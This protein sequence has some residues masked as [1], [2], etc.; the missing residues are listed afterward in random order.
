[1]RRL[2]LL[3]LLASAPLARAHPV[4]KDTHDRTLVVR[5]T[6]TGVVVDYRL[7]ADAAR[8][9]EDL[10]KEQAAEAGGDRRRLLEVYLRWVAEH[11]AANLDARLDGKELEFAVAAKS[12]RETDSIACDVRLEAGWELGEGKRHRFAF[13]EACLHN[14]RKG[15]LH[16]SL[17]AS[18]SLQAADIVAPDDADLRRTGDRDDK[19]D[20]R[21][22]T[23]S[24][25]ILATPEWLPARVRPALPP[26][27]GFR[28]ASTFPQAKAKPLAGDPEA[29]AKPGAYEAVE[30]GKGGWHLIDLLFDTRQGLAVLLLLAALFGA[31]HA[32][33]PGHGKTMVAAYLIGQRGTTWHAIVLGLV[34]T[35]THTS[36]VIVLALLLPMLFPGVPKDSQKAAL[37]LVAGALLAGMGLW[38]LMQRLAGRA[39]HTHPEEAEGKPGW[40]QLVVLGISGGLVPCWDAIL[41]LG[42]AIGKGLL[43]L[44]LPLVLAFSAGLAAVLVAVGIAVVKAREALLSRRERA[45]GEPSLGRWDRVLAWLGKALPL[46][47]AAAIIGLGLWMCFD[48]A[49]GAE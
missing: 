8:A 10:S 36:S 14:E 38:L 48:A 33:T 2:C 24:A 47:S 35:L 40:W 30:K 4:P 44:A 17:V 49:H 43:W 11:V 28:A 15:L 7:E 20:E 31:A 23:A 19:T 16:L 45:D 1:M 21:L 29:M 6:A 26:E 18:E 41:I 3:L 46:V 9:Y 22:R 12:V 5:L 34:T 27:T 39:D 42:V 25:T 32:L 13:R 37:G